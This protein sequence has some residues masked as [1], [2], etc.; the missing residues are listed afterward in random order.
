MST[1]SDIS[2]AFHH[3]LTHPQGGVAGL[4][5]ELLA[6]CR[7]HALELDWQADRCRMRSPGGEWE[8][9]VDLPLRKSVFRAILARLAAL[10]NERAPNSAS[11]H[12]G[13]GELS[14]GADPAAVFRVTF[15][16][17]PAEQKLALRMQSL[18]MPDTSPGNGRHGKVVSDDETAGLR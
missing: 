17:T 7:E 6:V 8:Q 3:L 15:T 11:P 5:D 1:T 10:C 16:N 18:P 4:V 14:A 2:R 13:Q 12:G 9:L